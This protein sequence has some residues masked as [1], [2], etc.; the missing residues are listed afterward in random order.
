MFLSLADISA[1]RSY[2]PCHGPFAKQKS[3]DLLLTS[4][5]ERGPEW[6]LYDTD[7]ASIVPHSVGRAGRVQRSVASIVFRSCE[8]TGVAGNEFPTGEAP[9]IGPK[10]DLYRLVSGPPIGSK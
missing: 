2:S 5:A 10:P 7:V 6:P 1:I 4:S 3:L 8:T 9:D